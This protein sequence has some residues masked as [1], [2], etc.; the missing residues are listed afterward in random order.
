MT[1][2]ELRLIGYSFEQQDTWWI[3]KWKDVEEKNRSLHITG[4]RTTPEIP[5]KK[6]KKATTKI[7]KRIVELVE[8]RTGH[9]QKRAA[10]T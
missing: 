3:I 6:Y 9:L 5:W 7:S 4:R 2:W 1:L 8:I 10:L